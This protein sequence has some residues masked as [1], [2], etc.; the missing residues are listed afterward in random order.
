MSEPDWLRAGRKFLGTQEIAGKKHN[1]LIVEW[2]EKSGHGWIKDDETA[3][4]AAFA[5]AMLEEV[6]IKGSNSVAARS[7]L[8]WGKESKAVPGAI[9]VLWRGS[10]G[11]AQ[12]HVG[13]LVK[14]S[15]TH[16]LLLGGNQGN[17]VSIASY[18]KSQVLGY[19]WPARLRTSRTVGGSGVAGVG[20]TALITD[21]SVD[22]VNAAQ[23]AEF[24][25]SAGTI[26]GMVLGV[27][28]LGGALV[29][30]YARW[31][32]AGRPVPWKRSNLDADD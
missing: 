3:W 32:D 4:C 28:I 9:V 2:F 23:Q 15:D 22:I 20:G 24:S 11:G 29:A 26:F 17:A 19:R 27:L 16:V 7:F 31:D 8:K 30:L 21:A 18:P 14:E 13:F 12:G 25:L 5:N 10:K 6:G 1:P